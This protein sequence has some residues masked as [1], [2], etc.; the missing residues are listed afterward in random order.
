MNSQKPMIKQ[1]WL[2][3]LL[4]VLAIV[5]LSL[6]VTQ[7][8]TDIRYTVLVAS[9]VLITFLFRLFI[10]RKSFLSLGFNWRGHSNEAALGFFSGIS[11]IG[12]GTLILTFAGYLS[13]IGFSYTNEILQTV[14]F[15]VAV[16]FI[17]ELLFRGYL[18][19]NLMQSVNKWIALFITAL[20]FALV[21][22]NN[23]D[24]TIVPV[25][26]VFVAGFLLGINYIYTKNLWFSIFLHFIW[27]VF[28]GPVLGYEVSG[29]DMPAVLEQNLDG[30]DLLTGG[31]FGFEGSIIC[32]VLIILFTAWFAY[33]FSRR[34]RF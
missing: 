3:A 2:R 8:G 26:N 16:A 17:E 30:P 25:L 1:G 12:I 27:N 18:L 5:G 15:L 13:F 33:T 21:H 32:L 7:L 24:V 10:D 14:G 9:V 23:P 19:N 11:I 6:A 20:L 29:F 22:T 28:Q 31:T 4:Y 34:Y